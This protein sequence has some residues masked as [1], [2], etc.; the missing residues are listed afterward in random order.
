M[1][2]CSPADIKKPRRP[3]VW[4]CTLFSGTFTAIQQ[5]T[6][7]RQRATH[8]DCMHHSDCLGD[9]SYDLHCFAHKMNI[10]CLTSIWRQTYAR[11]YWH[12]LTHKHAKR[13]RSLAPLLVTCNYVA[14]MSLI[15][16]TGWKL[17]NVKQLASTGKCLAVWNINVLICERWQKGK[18]FPYNFPL[19]LMF[20]FTELSLKENW[21]T[22]CFAGWLSPDGHVRSRLAGW[23]ANGPALGPWLD[24]EEKEEKK[25]NNGG[26]KGMIGLSVVK[27]IDGFRSE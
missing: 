17:R 3:R 12:S 1:V 24:G 6:R 13:R 25:I 7:I 18:Y 5:H 22:E 16:C 27:G 19:P 4:A 23:Q 2:Q 10:C 21:L 11:V 15:F 20:T 9:K 26:R 14:M 8:A